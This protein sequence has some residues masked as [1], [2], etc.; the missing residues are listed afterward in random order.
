[1]FLTGNVCKKV[2]NKMFVRENVCKK[3]GKKI[4]LVGNVCKESANVLRYPTQVPSSFREG[5]LTIGE[6]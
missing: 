2:R 3:T 4:F 5:W 1:M 6:D